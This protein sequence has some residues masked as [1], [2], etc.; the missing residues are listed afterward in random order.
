MSDP[1]GLSILRTVGGLLATKRFT[2]QPVAQVWLRSTIPKV[3]LLMRYR[4]YCRH[5]FRMSGA[6]GNYHRPPDLSVV[7]LKFIFSTG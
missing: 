1:G 5:V 6:S 2:W 3:S 7:F 4:S